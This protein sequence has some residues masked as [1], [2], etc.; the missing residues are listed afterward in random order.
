MWNI[1]AY[2]CCNKFLSE[3]VLG[4]IEEN[5]CK[6]PSTNGFRPAI[7][8]LYRDGLD[9]LSP[10]SYYFFKHEHENIRDNIDC[11]VLKATKEK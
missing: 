1:D 2:M 10:L 4:A 7:A 3:P 8:D 6:G 11:T 5:I 9:P